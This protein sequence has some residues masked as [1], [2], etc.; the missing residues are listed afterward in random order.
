MADVSGNLTVVVAGITATAGILGSLAGGSLQAWSTARAVKAQAESNRHV[1]A[2]DRFAT[3]QMHK[4][5]VY[6]SLLNAIQTYISAD[7]ETDDGEVMIC[8]NRA[9]VVAHVGL[10]TALMELQEDLT[11]LEDLATRRDL[12]EH[13]TA[14]VRQHG[15]DT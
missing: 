3:W 13:L 11:V 12:V 6:A 9:V 10:R 8:I 7:G 15:N 14:D 4:R 5:E 1:A 2:S